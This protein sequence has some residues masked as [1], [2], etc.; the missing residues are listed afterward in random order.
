MGYRLKISFLR[1]HNF[2]K[3]EEAEESHLGLGEDTRSSDAEKRRS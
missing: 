1:V 3:K 2:T